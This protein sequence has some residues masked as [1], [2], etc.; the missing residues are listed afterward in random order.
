MAASTRRRKPDAPEG[1]LL[2]YTPD[3]G[4]LTTKQQNAIRRLQ[5]PGRMRVKQSL[6]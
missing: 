6:F 1:I 4:P 3:N 2:R 5:Q